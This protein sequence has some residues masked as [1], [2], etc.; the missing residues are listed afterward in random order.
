MPDM[1]RRLVEP[2]IWRVMLDGQV[3]VIF[4]RGSK[5][6]LGPIITEHIDILDWN[7]MVYTSLERNE[8]YLP[9]VPRPE[10]LPKDGMVFYSGTNAYFMY[11]CSQSH[12][13]FNLQHY[14]STQDPNPEFSTFGEDE[15]STIENPRFL[16]F[17]EW[18]N[19][20]YAAIF[21]PK[22]RT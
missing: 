7:S 10:V 18:I 13:F 12:D 16:N 22:G 8:E 9:P 5:T 6:M 17:R 11:H 20:P 3:K 15:I 1:P 19:G 14:A 2:D 21:V 4:A